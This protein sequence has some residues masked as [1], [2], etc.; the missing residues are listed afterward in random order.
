MSTMALQPDLLS[1]HVDTTH[2][3]FLFSQIEE[4]SR[5]QECN[6]FRAFQCEAIRSH[7]ISQCKKYQHIPG[8][9]KIEELVMSWLTNPDHTSYQSLV[10]KLQV[11]FFHHQESK[12]DCCANQFGLLTALTGFGVTDLS[13]SNPFDDNGMVGKGESNTQLIQAIERS[14]KHL[15][16]KENFFKFAVYGMGLDCTELD[17]GS[18]G[19]HRFTFVQYPTMK[20]GKVKIRYRC[21]QSYLNEY[22]LCEQIQSEKEQQ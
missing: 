14:K 6:P 4:M 13:T 17:G 21:F 16:T 19:G 11:T 15:K 2:T 7:V 8:I 9:K 3:D 12:N 5:N 22:S 1:C 20:N 18:Y 10:S